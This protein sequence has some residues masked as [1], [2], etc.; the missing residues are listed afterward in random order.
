MESAFFLDPEIERLA[1]LTLRFNLLE[2]DLKCGQPVLV[3][4]WV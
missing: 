2:C 3:G 4:G 1:R